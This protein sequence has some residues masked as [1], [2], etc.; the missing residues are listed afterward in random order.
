MNDL[1]DRGVF[2]GLRVRFEKEPFIP[3]DGVK[4]FIDGFHF[5]PS[6]EATTRVIESGDLID[7]DQGFHVVF[8]RRPVSVVRVSVMNPIPS[9]GLY[10]VERRPG[11]KRS[12]F[13]ME[14]LLAGRGL[15]S[16]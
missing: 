7:V 6:V 16:V 5:D 2:R 11:I 1:G 9:G 4:R 14:G 15:V 12:R 10:H 8:F 3:E 13:I